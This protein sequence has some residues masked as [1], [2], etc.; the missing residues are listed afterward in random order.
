MVT[1]FGR[2][3]RI[4]AGM[5]LSMVDIAIPVASAAAAAAAAQQQLVVYQPDIAPP[6]TSVTERKAKL[7]LIIGT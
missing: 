6:I 4:H 7:S 5:Q 1:N 3:C 2:A